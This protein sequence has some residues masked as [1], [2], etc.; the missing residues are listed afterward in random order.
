MKRLTPSCEQPSLKLVTGTQEKSD[1]ELVILCQQKDPLAF[2]TL[3]RRYQRS[4]YNSL[5]QMAPDW[6]NTA[7]L[8]QEVFIR[9]WRS[10]HN[11]RNPRAFRSWLHQIA[12]NL[13]YDELRKRPKQVHTISMDEPMDI[14]E[15]EDS[16]TRDIA[17]TSALPD[18][19]AQRKELTALIHKAMAELP[20]QFR[21]AIVL[22]ELQGLSYEEIAVLTRSEMGTVKSRIARARNKIQELL[23]PYLLETAA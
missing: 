8:V 7:D 12:T 11:L 9:A 5:Y 18:E 15:G 20:E 1:A 2:Q 13:F 17:D 16:A 22:R 14:E 23:E 21:V 6:N 3:V 4:V 19:C 10:I